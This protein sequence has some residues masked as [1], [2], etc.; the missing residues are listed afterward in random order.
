M[1]YFSISEVI[2]KAWELTKKFGLVL[3]VVYFVLELIQYVIGQLFTPA[4]DQ[5]ALSAAISEQDWKTIMEM[6]YSNPTGTI[7]G[8]IIGAIITLGFM[9]C[10]LQMAKGKADS[11]SFD[12]WKQDVMVYVNYVVVSII[13]KILT[14]LGLLLC[15]VPGI[16]ISARFDFAEICA[17]D[18]PEKGIMGCLSYSW[19]MTEG[20]AMN[21][22]GLII[23]Q[24]FILAIGIAMCCIGILPAAVIVAFADVVAYL[25]LSNYFNESEKTDFVEAE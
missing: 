17:I 24:L 22:M 7:L 16:Y 23:V 1:V 15:I 21:I 4:I 6:Y 10:V 5:N 12:F 13:V 11:V 3:I 25:I 18:H 2:D 14:Y 8:S 20:N 19:K 9:N